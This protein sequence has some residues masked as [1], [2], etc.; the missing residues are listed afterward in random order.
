MLDLAELYKFIDF[1]IRDASP[2]RTALMPASNL[3]TGTQFLGIP[4]A[5]VHEQ[6]KDFVRSRIYFYFTDISCKQNVASHGVM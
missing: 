4:P 6:L 3:R 2:V 5:Q 1:A